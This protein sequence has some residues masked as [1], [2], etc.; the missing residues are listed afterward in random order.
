[1]KKVLFL[2]ALALSL[3]AAIAAAQEAHPRAIEFSAGALVFADDGT[4]TEG[5]LGA[6]ARYY[7]SPRVAIGP[8]ILFVQGN[9]HR[10]IIAT[11]NLTFD[12]VTQAAGRRPAVI[13]FAV[14]GGGMFQTRDRAPRGG[15]TSSEG[16]F[17]AG[18]GVRGVVSERFLVG[19]EARIG[20]ELHVRFNGIVG[21]T[22]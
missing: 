15:F 10:H 7:V 21:W 1:M 2:T 11:G 3:P 18:G 9:N 17:T 20:W 5:M 16:A 13:P 19:A 22:F 6:A 12:F 8:E 14:L 4:V